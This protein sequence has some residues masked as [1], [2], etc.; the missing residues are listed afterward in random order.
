MWKRKICYCC[1]SLVLLLVLVPQYLSAVQIDQELSLQQTRL[2][3]QLREALTNSRQ[4]MIELE[5]YYSGL[6][7]GLRDSLERQS[8]ELTML[9]DYL[10]STMN[11]F[12]SLSEELQ[13][14][15]ILL[16]VERDRRIRQERISIVI[17]V[18][19]GLV[20]TVNIVMIIMYFT[21]GSI[22]PVKAKRVLRI[23]R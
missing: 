11:S 5:N 21:T 16:A 15:G 8:G 7:A 13:N 9:S 19:G 6:I 3:S 20:L 12:R 4:S 14:S 17:G 1:F 23:M 10:T 22:I 18:I 2:S